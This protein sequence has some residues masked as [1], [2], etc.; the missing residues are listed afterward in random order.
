MLNIIVTSRRKQEDFVAVQ[1]D[2]GILPVSARHFV[3]VLT[4]CAVSLV[5]ALP[6]GNLVPLTIEA[7][8]Y[9]ALLNKGTGSDNEQSYLQNESNS[10]VEI[11]ADAGSRE[12]YDDVVLPSTFF[13]EQALA[14]A[15]SDDDD[16][17]SDES[18]SQENVPATPTLRERFVANNDQ[19]IDENLKE[20][21]Q[22]TEVN[23]KDQQ[24][25]ELATNTA[26]KDE[27]LEQKN[28]PQQDN[29]ITTEKQNTAEQLLAR[30]SLAPDAQETQEAQEIDEQNS[31]LGNELPKFGLQS[32]DNSQVRV[33]MLDADQDRIR[34][35][36]ALLQSDNVPVLSALQAYAPEND[37]PK[38]PDGDWYKQTVHKGDNI[39][40]IFNYLN[41]P[42]GTLA[43]IQKVASKK[44]LALKV[45][46]QL[47]FLIDDKNNVLELVKPVDSNEQ[48]RFTRMDPKQEFVA[49]HESL[50]AHVDNE[51]AI[52]AFADAEKMP[53][54]VEAAKDR[55]KAQEEAKI[56]AQKEAALE[57]ENARNRP[58]LVI[59]TV[60]KG[61]NFKSASKRIGLTQANMNSLR[62]A[63]A[64]KVN[65]NKLAAGDSFRVLFNGV[66][67]KSAISAV[68]FNTARNGKVSLYRHPDTG[69]LYEEDGYKPTTGVF[70]RFP[71]NVALQVSS[72]FNPRRLNPVRRKIAP[73]NGVDLRMPIG[74]PVYAPSDGVVTYASFMRGGGYT[75]IIKHMGA[76][77][78]VYMH[79]SKMHVKKGQRVHLGQQIA[80]SG[81]TGRST[82]P[83][84][85]YEIRIND[86]SVDPLKVDL[87]SGSQR[88]AQE[89]RR[90]FDSTVKILKSD[91]YQE[92]LAL[93]K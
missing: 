21:T 60:Q 16:T 35:V 76:Y 90:K 15:I 32:D 40:V 3:A 22:N 30:N 63:L 14:D 11:A 7:S 47:H 6:F 68:E 18:T 20:T 59:A 54:A 12:N 38:R 80:K 52:T 10:D 1:K 66:G 64:G 57:R 26:S 91:L 49:I 51:N 42:N 69:N 55:A 78:T 65:L 82:G 24:S 48:V 46:S 53:N 85:H 29:V 56:L 88:L 74:T 8:P 39:S 77:S 92:S 31:N 81:N 28:I 5:S 89:R 45:G 27:N 70:K 34:R 67:T 44:D 72:P 75:V 2:T 62:Q 23:K 87:P 93:R 9:I 4:V 37:E 58:R 73:H 50:N 83:H 79:L 84:L 41:L 17:N 19:K 71:V 25:S 61:E 33:P 13:S 86:R 43:Q 36:M